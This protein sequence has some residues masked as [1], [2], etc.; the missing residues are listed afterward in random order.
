MQ[1]P[2]L[3]AGV[4][5]NACDRTDYSAAQGQQIEAYD[6]QQYRIASPGV[7]RVDQALGRG[8]N[9]PRGSAFSLGVF[10]NECLLAT[11][12]HVVVA[13]RGLAAIG[14]VVQASN[15]DRFPTQVKS[16]NASADLAILATPATNIKACPQLK[17]ASTS[18]D[19][20]AGKD[21]LVAIGHPAGSKLQFISGGP[22]EKKGRSHI[23]I[24]PKGISNPW[25]Y[26][27]TVEATAQVIK[28]MSGSPVFANGQV[29]GAVQGLVGNREMIVTPV[30][31]LSALLNKTL[32]TKNKTGACDYNQAKQELN[33]RL[34]AGDLLNASF[35]KS[36]SQER[37]YYRFNFGQGLQFDEINKTCTWSDG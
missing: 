26:G 32:T 13:D 1:I 35:F 17:L 30:D 28:G 21:R 9:G 20:V 18:G 29:F 31:D 19:L 14:L 16:W 6:L 22:V 2:T 37:S 34:A 15:G 7:F 33:Q 36:S 12:Y 25:A 23:E 10:G 3:K 8:N 4:M 5:A 11:D 27:K 24:D